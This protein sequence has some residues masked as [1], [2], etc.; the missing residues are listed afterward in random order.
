M[1]EQYSKSNLIHLAKNWQIHEAWMLVKIWAGMLLASNLCVFVLAFQH[2]HTKQSQNHGW[3]VFQVK[4][5]SFGKKIDRFVSHEC[6]WRF[7]QECRLL[8]IYGG[9]WQHFNIFTQNNAKIMDE[10]YSK[11]N[12]IHW[13][14]KLT[15]SWSMN[16]GEDWGKFGK[17]TFGHSWFKWK[18]DCCCRSTTND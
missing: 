5:H 2:L 11:S 6:W 4:P 17:Q 13:R 16:A 15:D 3:A 8:A 12:L 7:E 10:Q 1:N 9:L 14:K 18:L